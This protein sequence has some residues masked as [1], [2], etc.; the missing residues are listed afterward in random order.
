MISLKSVSVDAPGLGSAKLQSLWQNGRFQGLCGL[1]FLASDGFVVLRGM[2][3]FQELRELL[4]VLNFPH[5][6]LSKYTGLKHQAWHET[7]H[8]FCGPL[9]DPLDLEQS[10]HGA[11]D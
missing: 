4:S 3:P 11:G 7:T 8:R 10:N 5:T 9:L 2:N 6:N 1:Y